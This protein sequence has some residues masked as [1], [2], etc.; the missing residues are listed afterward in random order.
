[1]GRD[2]TVDVLYLGNRGVHLLAQTQLNRNAVVTA[3]HNLPLFF[4]Q[5][6]QASLDALPLTLAQLIGE[7]DSPIGNPLLPAGFPLPISSHMPLGNSKYHGLAVDVN[8]RF[9]NHLLFKAGYTWSHLMDDST[10]ELNSTS[11]SPRRAEDFN[12]RRKEWASS[13]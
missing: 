11:L 13:L 3:N 2:Y 5:P 9:S 10:A 12:N 7:R 8:K 1:F 6:S 4:S